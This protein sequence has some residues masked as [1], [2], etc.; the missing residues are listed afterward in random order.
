MINKVNI[1]FWKGNILAMMYSKK[2]KS[3]IIIIIQLVA[4]FFKGKN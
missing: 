2:K 3:I 4:K 1:K